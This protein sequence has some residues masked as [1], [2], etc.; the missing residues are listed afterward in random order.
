MDAYR[1]VACSFDDELEA[2]AT[3]RQDCQI[4]YRDEEGQKQTVTSKIIDV[5][6]ANRA[7]FIKLQDGTIIR[8]DHLISVNDKPIQF[9]H[10]TFS[11]S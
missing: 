5:Y 6:A 3:L 11:C 4:I 8:L 7:D 9:A 1:L 10:S 2:W